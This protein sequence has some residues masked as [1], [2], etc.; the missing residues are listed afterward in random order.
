MTIP[1]PAVLDDNGLRRLWSRARHPDAVDPDWPDRTLRAACA[2]AGVEFVAL[3]DHL[4]RSHFKATDDHLTEAG[5]RLLAGVLRS[6]YRRQAR[7]V[8]P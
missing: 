5:H 3:K 6:V 4:R 8:P 7:S 2:T 1:S